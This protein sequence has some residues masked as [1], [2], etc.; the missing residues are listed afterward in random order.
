MF[1]PAS[2]GIITQVHVLEAHS[3][4]LAASVVVSTILAMTVT[5]IVFR[6]ATLR[7]TPGHKNER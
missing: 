6:W 1:V 7:A 5:A 3:L 2:V 4:A